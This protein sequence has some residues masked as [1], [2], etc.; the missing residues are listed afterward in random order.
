MAEIAEGGGC[1]VVDP[2]DVD[3]LE[4]AMSRLLS[5]DRLLDQLRLEAAARPTRTWDEYAEELWVF[6]VESNAP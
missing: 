6:L 3:S 4:N 1:L 2:R 5:D